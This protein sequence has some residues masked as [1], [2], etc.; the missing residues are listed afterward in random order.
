M[1][2]E[3]E[4]QYWLEKKESVPDGVRR[5]ALGRVEQALER[6]A[7]DDPEAIHGARKD[8]KKLRAVLR[9]VR[10]PLGDKRY[11]AENERYRDAA[12]LLSDARDAEVKVETL[13][14]LSERF[15]AKLPAGPVAAW[16]LMLKDERDQLGDETGD[17]LSS[18]LEEAAERIGAGREEIAAWPLEDDSWDLIE[19]GLLRGYR[20]GRRA[21][22]RAR[23]GERAEDVHEWRKR[24]KDLWYDLRLLHGTW[25]PVV[26]ETAGQAHELADLLGDHHDLDLLAADLRARQTIDEREAIYKL[27]ER[28]QQ[29]LLKRAIKLGERLFA[30]K[31]KAFRRRFKGYWRAW[32]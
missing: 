17:G 14:A 24:T 5:I 4:R 19:A 7:G 10:E 29:Q 3:I 22:K 23:S 6:L 31:P 12:R 15:G 18:R 21:M 30:E 8:L 28:R 27:I 1:A 2:G 13:A 32:R 11:R 16:R 20:R 9:L 25:K 26:G